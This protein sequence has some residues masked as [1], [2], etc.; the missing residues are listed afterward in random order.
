MGKEIKG[1]VV[2]VVTPFRQD[3]SI[4]EDAL[5]QIVNYLVGAGVHGLFPSGSQGE[6]WALTTDEKKRVMD[7]VIEEAAGRVFV[8]PS[9]GAVTTRE[10][11][12]LTRHAERSGADAV[13][14]ITPFFIR[15]SADEL[16]RHY[17]AIANSVSI[18]VLAYS[19]PDRTSLPITPAVAAAIAR[20]AGNFAGIKDSSGDLTNTM[21]YIEE[22]PPHFRTFMGRDTLIYAGLVYGCVGAVAAT[23]NVAP[24]LVVGI[25]DAFMAGDRDLALQRQRR[26]APLRRAFTL[27]S[28]PV[29]VKDAMELMGLPAGPCRAPIRSLEGQAR[30]TLIAILRD[31]GK[32]Q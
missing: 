1:I 27:G 31:M 17:V 6:F 32:L 28:F 7:V 29:V 2:P 9:T 23:A 4:N 16:R 22:C 3:E 20:E 11:I 30:Q 5:R 25:Y 18:P 13:S 15:P 24:E 14:V 10:S 19:N 21:A 12:E 26:L 8:M